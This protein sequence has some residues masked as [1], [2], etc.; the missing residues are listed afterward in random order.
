MYVG[1]HGT[2]PESVEEELPAGNVG[3]GGPFLS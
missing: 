3:R 2:G 1:K